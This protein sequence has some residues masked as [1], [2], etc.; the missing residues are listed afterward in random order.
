MMPS[1]GKNAQRSN[2]YSIEVA[3]ASAPK[4]AAAMPLMPN[5]KPKKTPE[6]MP[7][8]LGTNSCA[9]T[10]IAENADDN[11]SPITTDNTAVQNK[12]Q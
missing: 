4:P 5:I 9:S 1:S 10:T 12:L 8:L 7:I 11:T 6:I 2:M 3:S